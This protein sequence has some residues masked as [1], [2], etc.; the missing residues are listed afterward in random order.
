VDGGGCERRTARLRR[1][2]HRSGTGG[3]AQRWNRLAGSGGRRGHDHRPG[4]LRSHARCSQ[5][6]A[7]RH[8]ACE[9]RADSGPIGADA[10]V[11][12][13][14][15]AL[16]FG[17]VFTG[18]LTFGVVFVGALTITLTFA[19]PVPVPV[20]RVP[21]IDLAARGPGPIGPRQAVRADR[22]PAQVGG[23]VRRGGLTSR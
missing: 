12:D 6:V 5:A 18:A 10:R 21:V 2:P 16:T 1:L 20:I 7:Y 22:G 14:A 8:A 11:V 9:L 3:P 13:F 23:L 19:Y 17:V 4:P 15:G